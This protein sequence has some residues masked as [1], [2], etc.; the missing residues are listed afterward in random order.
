M[1][2]SNIIRPQII[3][4]NMKAINKDDALQQLADLFLKDGVINS[5]QDYINAVYERE[6]EGP[7]GMG[8]FV[9]IP[10]GKSDCIVKT[11]V[12]FARLKNPIEWETL[13]GAPV[14]LI[15]LFAVPNNNRNIDHLKVLSQL[16]ATL[17]YEETLEQL[18]KADTPRKVIDILSF[19]ATS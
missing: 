7:T 12:A 14:K 1:D 3:N 5:K 11:S 10:H 4:L 2:F 19:Q 8:N 17:A 6:K 13:D 16:A 15:F 18:K 9:A